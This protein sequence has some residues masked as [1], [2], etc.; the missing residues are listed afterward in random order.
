GAALPS[1]DG[2]GGLARRPRDHA[3]RR[4]PS[5]RGL[6]ASPRGCVAL[7]PPGRHRAVRG[8]RRRGRVGTPAL[9][10]RASALHRRRSPRGPRRCTRRARARAGLPARRGDVSPQRRRLAF[11]GPLPPVHSGIADYARDL[12]PHLLG[13]FHIDVFVDDRHP[14]VT[15]GAYGTLPL[16][17]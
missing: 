14:L 6:A 7:A 10:R 2:T 12:L 5:T 17:P 11:V 3:D 13:D 9:A 16:Y 15:E 8:A 1:R 4:S